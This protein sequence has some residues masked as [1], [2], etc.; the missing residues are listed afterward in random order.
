M[1]THEEFT[2]FNK[3]LMSLV[4]ITIVLM[5]VATAAAIVQHHRTSD[6]API[7]KNIGKLAVSWDDQAA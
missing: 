1:E 2:I 6:D 5:A 7:G 3:F 4:T